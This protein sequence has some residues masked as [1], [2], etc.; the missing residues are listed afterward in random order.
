MYFY[1]HDFIEKIAQKGIYLR[2]KTFCPSENLDKDT[3]KY[4]YSNALQ[5]KKMN[6]LALFVFSERK[7]VGKRFANTKIIC[8]FALLY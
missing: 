7:K 8:N 4:P 2:S 1:Y 3:K 6:L 5:A